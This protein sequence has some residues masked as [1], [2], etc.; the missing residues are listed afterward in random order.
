LHQSWCR[1]SYW[2]RDE[3]GNA[4]FS[5]AND[6]FD[7]ELEPYVKDGR[8]LWVEL[9]KVAGWSFEESRATF[10]FFGIGGDRERQMLSGGQR[11]L[12]GLPDGEAMN[13]FDN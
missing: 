12:L 4:A 8:L 10:P 11:S 3:E 7:F 2:I 1:D 5:I 6:L 13:P 9:S